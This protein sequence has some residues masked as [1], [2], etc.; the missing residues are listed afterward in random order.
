MPGSGQ[1]RCSTFNDPL[2]SVSV[3]MWANRE[4][5]ESAILYT[6]SN[7]GNNYDYLINNEHNWIITETK[8]K[9]GNSSC[10]FNRGQNVI[11]RYDLTITGQQ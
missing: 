8:R 11:V 3:R 1:P 4:L 5:G 10:Y 9:D 7:D 2:G 6:T